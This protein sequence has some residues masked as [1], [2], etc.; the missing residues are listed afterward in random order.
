MV[1]VR[2]SKTVGDLQKRFPALQ[3][4]LRGLVAQ[5][6]ERVRKEERSVLLR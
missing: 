3:T 4:E 2:L 1:P 6:A 5:E